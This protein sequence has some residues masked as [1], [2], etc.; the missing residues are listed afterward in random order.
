[1]F[2][3]IYKYNEHTF[4]ESILYNKICAIVCL[5][6]QNKHVKHITYSL[7]QGQPLYMDNIK[8][9]LEGIRNF[10]P[11][12]TISYTESIS[13]IDEHCNLLNVSDFETAKQHK[14][15]YFPMCRYLKIYMSW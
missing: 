3:N 11:E 4:E 13:G 15:I 2:L 5:I 14:W 9:I 1:M 12:I 10:Y 8:T 7:F 6:E